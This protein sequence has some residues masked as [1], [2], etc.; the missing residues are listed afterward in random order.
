MKIK[1]A[2]MSS[3]D[4]P[5]YLDFWPIVSELWYKKFDIQPML[6]YFDDKSVDDIRKTAPYGSVLKKKII[7][8]IPLYVQCQWV[9]YY[10]ACNLDSIC[11]I[12]DIDMLPLSKYYFVDQI[13]GIG[14]DKYVHLNPCMDTYPNIP[15]CYHVAHSDTFGL[16]LGEH[17]DFETSIIEVLRDCSGIDAAHAD[18]KYWFVD[19]KYSTMRIN[20]H[21]DKSIFQFIKRDGGQNGHRI[22]RPDWRFDLDKV[23][24][25]WYYDC[26]SIR[27]YSQHKD[28]IDSI[29]NAALGL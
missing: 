9:R 27:P 4:N 7:Q 20:Q 23:R 14:D 16:V 6:V 26:H 12:S 3:D 17:N 25:D 29:K 22:D 19:E 1:Y 13:A 2:I 18:R 10:M 5:M 15:A 24:A 28:S 21:A 11:V 8:N